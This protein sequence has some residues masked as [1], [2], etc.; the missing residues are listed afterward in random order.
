MTRKYIPMI[1]DLE[2]RAGEIFQWEIKDWGVLDKRVTGPEFEIGGYKWQVGAASFRSS[3]GLQP[4][5][6]V[7][8][9]AHDG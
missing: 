1:N 2:E 4:V 8:D 3:E 9:Q 7:W 5:M 6:L